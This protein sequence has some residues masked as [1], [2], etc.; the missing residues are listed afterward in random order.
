M[1][2]ETSIL[3]YLYV[4]IL[5]S[6][7]GPE[8]RASCEIVLSP[9]ERGYRDHLKFEKDR[10]EYLFAHALTRFALS[11]HAPAVAPRTWR[12]SRSAHG[13][14]GITGPSH[15]PALH[16][17]LSHTT[18]LVACVVST[19]PRVGVDVEVI[20]QEAI[21]AGLAESLFAPVEAHA[22]RASQPDER[23]DCVARYWTLK[24]SYLKASGLGLALPLDQFWFVPTPE[25]TMRLEVASSID[26][27]ASW[28]F[29]ERRPTPGHRLAVA[30]GGEGSG[31]WNIDLRE[32]IVAPSFF[33]SSNDE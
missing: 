23:R 17:N 12:F 7:D 20:D 29:A 8:T 33:A 25:G 26:D 1:A 14:P 21:Q 11:H 6:V 4:A 5:D 24:E 30:A 13:K 28:R 27:G 3:V 2:G 18:G 19:H 15:A 31:P 10:C 16:F 22:L 32:T 9:G